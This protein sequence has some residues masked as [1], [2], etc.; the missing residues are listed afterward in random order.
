MKEGNIK[1]LIIAYWYAVENAASGQVQRHFVENLV[2]RGF[3]PTVVCASKKNDIFINGVRV[4][5]VPE[6]KL[7]KYLSK[8]LL[9]TRVGRF[10]RVPDM[11]RYSWNPRALRRIKGILCESDFDYV[12]TINNPSSSHLLGWRIKQEFRIPWIAQFYD[13]WTN[14]P[15]EYV[16]NKRIRLLNIELEKRVA[17]GTNLIL[18]TNDLMIRYWENLYG[19]IVK[20]K[21]FRLNLLTDVESPA[22]TS[23]NNKLVISHIGHFTKYR[24][25]LSFIEA[26]NMIKKEKPHL[27]NK[28]KVNYIGLVTDAERDLIKKYGLCDCFQLH[29]RLS[30]KDCTPFFEESSMFLIIDTQHNPNVFFPSK[31]LKYFYY[32]KPI[33]GITSHESVLK[34][35]LINSRNIFFEFGKERDLAQFLIGE[36]ECD[37]IYSNHDSEYWKKFSPDMVIREYKSLIENNILSQRIQ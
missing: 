10:L 6:N 7:L 35:E 26:I 14:N 29:G 19:G 21:I 27:L 24:N 12:H 28:L 23:P 2:K 30:E 8:L 1:V 15:T 34:D 16:S 5:G 36:L 11:A 9:K 33:L 17:E 32:R 18:H 3:S 37:G 13:P 31:I 20:N 22:V 4:I 25:S